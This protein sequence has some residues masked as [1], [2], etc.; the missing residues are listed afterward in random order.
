MIR[1]RLLLLI[2]LCFTWLTYAPSDAKAQDSPPSPI[3]PLP[4]LEPITAENAARLQELAVIG[5]GYLLSFDLSGDG[6]LLAVGTT[7]GVWFYDFN[8]LSAEPVYLYAGLGFKSDVRFSVTGEYLGVK[9][10]TPDGNISTSTLWRLEDDFSQSEMIGEGSVVGNG[11]YLLYSDGSLWDTVS[12]KRLL[13]D[14][15]NQNFFANDMSELVSNQ[16]NTLIALS[17]VPTDT[18]STQRKHIQLYSPDS[19]KPIRILE[20]DD[21]L[22]TRHISHLLFSG[23]GEYLLAAATQA[24]TSYETTIRAWKVDDLLSDEPVNWFDGHVIWQSSDGISEFTAQDNR[25]LIEHY[26]L[27][28]N[29]LDTDLIQMPDGNVQEQI[30]ASHLR[31]HPVSGEILIFDAQHPDQ[32]RVINHTT[33]VEMGLLGDFSGTFRHFILNEDHS[34]VL[35][36]NQTI[37]DYPTKITVRRRN[38]TDWQEIK[39]LRFDNQI[40]TIARFQPDGRAVVTSLSGQN[41]N[42]EIR[43]DL[44]DFDAGEVI[45]TIPTSFEVPPS[46]QM[47]DDGT[48]LLVTVLKER[49]LYDITVPESPKVTMLPSA[50]LFETRGYFSPDGQTLALTEFDN[51]HQ[52]LRMWDIESEKELGLITHRS[53]IPGGLRWTVDGTLL[54]LCETRGHNTNDIQLTFW[55]Y[56]GVLNDP[57]ITPYMTAGNGVACNM[58]SDFE[59][60]IVIPTYRNGIEVWQRG[61]IGVSQLIG[62][63][64]AN[65]WKIAEVNPDGTVLLGVEYYGQMMAWSFID[66]EKI[67]TF[68]FVPWP[69]IDLLFMDEGRLLVMPGSDGTIRL[70][71][72]RVETVD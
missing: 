3:F 23:D 37:D 38:T 16:Q 71:G 8:D 54:V 42:T 50:Q 57:F 69:V 12:Q 13:L 41:F 47:N 48:L 43:I 63:D 64:K 66:G 11:R 18:D 7:A 19:S 65:R 9:A 45:Y 70:W 4:A 20:I 67:A 1:P 5:R 62:A 14:G 29:R 33:G 53:I 32:W 28:S 55:S 44:W 72:V 21:T 22:P 51:E 24:E 58:G 10:Y 40:D 52:L 59:S 56:W 27:N 15:L 60:S 35:T 25:L 68:D 39:A 2:F 46:I 6:N 26:K 34:Q 36:V 17:S 30:D 31:F 61:Y 49:W